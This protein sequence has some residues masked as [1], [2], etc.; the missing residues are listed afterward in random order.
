MR[1]FTFI[2]RRTVETSGSKLEKLTKITFKCCFRF[3]HLYKE[4]KEIFFL[5]LVQKK[6]RGLTLIPS[7]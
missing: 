4:S 1:F 3:G 5:S 2:M 6:G 7:G